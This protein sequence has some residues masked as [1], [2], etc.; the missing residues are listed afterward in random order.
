MTMLL[1]NLSTMAVGVVAYW[2]GSSAGSARN[3]EE[4]RRA[5]ER[6]DEELR[7]AREGGTPQG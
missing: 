5:S 2:V 4:L 3:D 6:K 7:R 1:G